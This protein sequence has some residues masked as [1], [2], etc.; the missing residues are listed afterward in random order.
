[1][2]YPWGETPVPGRMGSAIMAPAMTIACFRRALAA[3]LLACVFATTPGHAQ[4]WAWDDGTVPFVV[5]PEEVVDRM[6]RIADVGA[7]TT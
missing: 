7:G 4:S 1:M 6:L 3:V 2:N 5:S